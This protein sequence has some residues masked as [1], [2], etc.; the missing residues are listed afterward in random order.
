M[1]A[2]LIIVFLLQVVPVYANC[3]VIE[4]TCI[5]GPET[6]V[7]EG[8][9]IFKECWEYKVNYKC[10][11]EDY[12]NHCHA[13]ENAPGCEVIS[14]HC[15]D[16]SCNR[17]KNTF[18]CGNLLAQVGTT[19]FLGSEYTIAKDQLDTS[20]CQPHIANG[21][22]ETDKTCV[23]GPS[24]KV[25]NG[26]EVYKDCWEYKSTYSCYGDSLISDCDEYTKSCTFISEKCLSDDTGKCKHLEK[27]FNC[28]QNIGQAPVTMQCSGVNYCISGDCESQEIKPNQNM[29]KSLSALS[30]LKNLNVEKGDCLDGNA[31]KCPIFKGDLK[32]CRVDLLNSLNCC[33]NSGWLKDIKFAQCN[34]DER[35]LVSSKEDGLC[36]KVGS[37]CSTKFG[38]TCLEKKKSYCCFGSKISRIIH[39]QGRKQLVISWGSA[40][41]P[42]CRAL[43][44]DELQRL[45]FD[46]LDL[47]ESFNELIS[48]ANPLKLN[49]SPSQDQEIK[50]RI[51]EYYGN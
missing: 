22:T 7:I 30:M 45:D 49:G 28:S 12:T 18:K 40:K 3:E 51:K 5:S 29:G 23:D 19:T 11:S 35:L 4:Q 2:I 1:R 17:I 50:R 48:K 44:V 32:Q 33:K 21:C 36:H 43:T 10:L 39:E 13:I 8:H 31:K 16:E 14:T 41:N 47:S 24:T 34:E 9:N 25:I 20:D 37:Y 42:N 46:K 38:N 15:D 26:K 6:R 27:K